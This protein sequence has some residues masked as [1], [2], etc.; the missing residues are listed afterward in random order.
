LNLK[1][2]FL[3]VSLLPFNGFAERAKMSFHD[4]GHHQAQAD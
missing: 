2:S 3:I 4:G 1:L